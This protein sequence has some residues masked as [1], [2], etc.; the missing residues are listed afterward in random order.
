[1]DH[2]MVYIS[3]RAFYWYL[4]KWCVLKYI[5]CINVILVLFMCISLFV[6]Y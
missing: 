2:T 1:M 6:D 3:F 5:I 4:K